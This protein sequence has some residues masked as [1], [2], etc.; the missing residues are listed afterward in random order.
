MATH[1][2]ATLGAMLGPLLVAWL[3][4]RG[5]WEASFHWAGRA[6]LALAAIALVL[7]FPAPDTAPRS[8]LHGDTGS[9]FSPALAP[10]AAIGF[11]YV[12]VEA[13]ATLF[14]VP[15][16]SGSL[17]L[18][19]ERGQYAISAFWFG[20]LAGRIAVLAHRGAPGAALL[21]GSGLAGASV[22]MGG[23]ALG[24]SSVEAFFALIGVAMGCVYPLVIALTGQRFPHARGAAAGLVAGAGALGGFVVPW[25]TGTVGDFAGIG[26]AVGSLAA[27]SLVVAIA[28]IAP[29]RS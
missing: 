12:G 1:A 22:L 16:A 14:A 24:V 6:H 29:L 5:G 21:L 13:S 15:Y 10:L 18:P 8:R 28:A 17:E 20:L 3:A 7:R 9:L 25:V 27:W 23:V 4:S 2:A 26:I 11:A 19:V